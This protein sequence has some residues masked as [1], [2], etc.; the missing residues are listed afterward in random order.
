[1]LLLLLLLSVESTVGTH[2]AVLVAGSK[3][4]WNYR[5]QADLCHAYHVVRNHGIHPDNI[6]V[7]MYD[8]VASDPHNP[9]PGKLFNKPA[10]LSSGYDV[11]EGCAID[12]R[13]EQVTPENF[14]RVLLGNS[15]TDGGK[16]LESTTEDR[17]FINFVD[18]GA[19]G[20]IG[21]PHSSLHALEF[22]ETIEKMHHNNM[23]KELVIYV[24]ACE[25]ASMFQHL[26]PQHLNVF[27]TTA[28]NAHES[29]WGTYC[30][31]HDFIAG[32]SINTCLGD[33]YSVNWME[34]SDKS[35]LSHETLNE[36]Y[37]KVRGKTKQ[38]HVMK[39][40]SEEIGD[41]PIDEFQSTVPEKAHLESNL[42]PSSVDSRDIALVTKFY[43]YLR[44]EAGSRT[45]LATELMEEIKHRETMDR[46]FSHVRS[47]LSIETL[48]DTVIPKNYACHRIALKAYE[49]SCGPFTDY[50]LKYE[51]I[52]IQAC[53]DLEDS[54]RISKVLVDACRKKT[55][56]LME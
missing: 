27:I 24:E 3:G 33:L 52:V 17:V 41:E 54:A 7:M 13:R 18:H 25:S 6:I 32:K 22:L 8:D 23:Y 44:A 47:K 29:S 45:M 26:L 30:P 12:Y 40:G 42:E 53:E 14:I 31:P 56:P 2:W 4:Y 46:V 39:F 28:A 51:R 43:T 15:S 37:E 20:L 16:V 49:A 38:S 50:S 10:F 19:V 48:R 1:M 21:F 36:Q 34:D 35:D 5:H 11:Y 9:Y 55:I